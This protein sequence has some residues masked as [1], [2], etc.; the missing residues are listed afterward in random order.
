MQQLSSMNNGKYAKRYT[1]E[2]RGDIYRLVVLEGMRPA[3]VAQR[4]HTIRQRI[5]NIVKRYAKKLSD[6]D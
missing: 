5:E 1:A 6:V 2:Q 4:Y 3:M